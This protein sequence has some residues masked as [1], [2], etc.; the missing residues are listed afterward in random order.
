MTNR[1]ST[2][3]ARSSSSSLLLP[4]LG[5]ILAVA[6]CSSAEPEPEPNAYTRQAICS[7]GGGGGD[8]CY[9]DGSGCPASCSVC[10]AS[11]SE[12]ITL[13]NKWMCDDSDPGGSGGGGGETGPGRRYYRS[14]ERSDEVVEVQYRLNPD[15]EANL[16]EVCGRAKVHADAQCTA[17][18][19][20]GFSGFVSGGFANQR[21][22]SAGGDFQT[23]ICEWQ[24]QC[25]YFWASP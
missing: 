19:T 2:F 5:A 25:D 12:R 18:S 11:A 1:L 8:G 24:S 6:G 3:A 14:S 20:L 23:C 17:S 16:Q 21:S 4:L 7:G 9:N 13:Q 22:C 10:Y 15:S